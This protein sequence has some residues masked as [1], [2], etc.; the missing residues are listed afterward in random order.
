MIVPSVVRIVAT[1]AALVSAAAAARLGSPATEP[2]GRPTAPPNRFV[3]EPTAA[4]ELRRLWA[5]SAAA[6]QERVACLGGERADGVTHITRVLVLEP[7]A[8]D[9]LGISATRSIETCG[10]PDW[11]GTVHTHIA[12]RDGEH[13]YPMFSGAD[14]GV[15]LMWWRR[16]QT[17]GTFCVLYTASDAHCEVDGVAVRQIGGRETDIQ[18]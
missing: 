7:G 9:S 13:P 15:M 12:L 14:R 3:L 18:Y 1:G 11:F 6:K 4:S 8:A 16:W 2:A 17:D 10:P 5:A